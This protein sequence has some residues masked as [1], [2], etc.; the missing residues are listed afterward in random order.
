MQVYRRFSSA[1]IF[2]CLLSVKY[3]SPWHILHAQQTQFPYRW[4]Y[5]RYKSRFIDSN[6]L[7]NKGE[8]GEWEREQSTS[9]V[10]RCFKGCVR[11]SQPVEVPKSVSYECAPT[12]WRHSDF[13]SIDVVEGR[14]SKGAREFL[15]SGGTR[16]LNFRFSRIATTA[17]NS[18][19]FPSPSLKPRPRDFPSRFVRS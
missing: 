5:R 10:D 16:R 3:P 2:S 18:P 12:S 13:N 11:N 14:V 19:P 17:A 15:S 1:G 4:M 7:F 6:V 9:S 8:E